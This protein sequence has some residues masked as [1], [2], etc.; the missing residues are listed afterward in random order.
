MD[1]NGL[2]QAEGHPGPQEEHVVTEDH[3]ADE[4]TSTQDERLGG[5]S[6]FCLHA[7]W[8]LWDS[9]D[10]PQKVFLVEDLG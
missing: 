5:M 4:E 1:I 6:V 7:E 9:G 3:D 8:R 2:Q 10:S